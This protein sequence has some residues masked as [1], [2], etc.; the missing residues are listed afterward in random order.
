MKTTWRLSTV[1]SCGGFTG[2]TGRVRSTSRWRGCSCFGSLTR[3][4]GF[5]LVLVGGRSYQSFWPIRGLARQRETGKFVRA[6]VGLLASVSSA[7]G[8]WG[9]GA[10]RWGCWDGIGPIFSNLSMDHESAASFRVEQN[11]RRSLTTTAAG[12]CHGATTD[13]SEACD[14]GELQVQRTAGMADAGGVR[15]QDAPGSQ[16]RGLSTD[17]PGWSDGVALA[18]WDQAR[19]GEGQRVGHV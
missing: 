17:G 2:E 7:S 13:G 12:A 4:V 9:L 19:L 14:P 1:L 16:Q 3:T 6:V 10:S 18:A 8:T 5:S 15:D 11:Q